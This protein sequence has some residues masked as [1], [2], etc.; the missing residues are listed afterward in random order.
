[1]VEEN[2]VSWKRVAAL[3]QPYRRRVIYVVVVVV[4]SSVIGIANPLLVQA[5]FDQALFGAGGVRLGLLVGLV[6]AMVTIALVAGGLGVLQT[7]ET[8]RLGQTVLR[9]LR[10]RLYVH[11]QSQSLSFFSGARTGDLQSRLSSD[12]S[13]AQNAVTTTLSSILSNAITFA[14]AIVAMLILSWQLTVVTLLVVPLFVIATRWVGVRRKQYTREAQQ[15]TATM[16]VITQET[17]SVS[18]ITLAKLFG[19]QQREIDRFQGAS[20]QLAEASQRQQVIGQTFFT[21]VQTFLGI[22]PVVVYLAAGFAIDGGTDISAGTVVAFTTLQSRLFFPVARMLETIVELSS[23]KALFGRIFAYLDVEPEIVEERSAIELGRGAITGVVAFDHVGFAY[24]EADVAALDG[25]D[26][27]AEPGQLIALVGPSGAGKSTVLQL[28]ARLYDPQAGS[29][30]IDGHDLRDLS[31]SSLANSVGFVTQESYLFAGSLRDNIAYGRSDAT[32]DDIVEAA[33]RA[34][35]HDRI[36]EFVDGYDTVVGE[37]GTR[38]SGG[39]RQRIAIARVLLA[40]PRVL[41]LDEATSALDTA[42][43]RRIQRALGELVSGR[44]TLAVAHR[45]STIQAAD[46]IHVVD[47]GQIVESGSHAELLALGGAYRSL[48]EEQFDGGR[49]ETR[50]SDG[51]VRSDGTVEYDHAEQRRLVRTAR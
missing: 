44:T 23:A 29:V 19:Q 38:L 33:Q 2:D 18:G 31:F 20:A 10:D 48:Y 45:L 24:P 22:T 4:T 32:I 14:S 43:E 5:V 34:A 6:V 47:R 11:L 37:R 25:I 28:V 46:R 8:N 35:I 12:V 17:L 1:M 16:S 13:N 36:L 15:H 50:C 39:E 9:D 3:F 40:D 26:F 41:V 51:V 7:I 27:T 42:S 21:M 49:V 30:T